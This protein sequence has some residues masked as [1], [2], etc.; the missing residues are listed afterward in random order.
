MRKPEGAR[1]NPYATPQDLPPL[2]TPDPLLLKQCRDG[3]QAYKDT[4][5]QTDLTPAKGT[6]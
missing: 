6:A 4:I 1:V 2:L 3:V 5:E